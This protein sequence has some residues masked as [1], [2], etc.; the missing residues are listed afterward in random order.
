MGK[1]RVL[2]RG[3]QQERGERERKGERRKKGQDRP[4]VIGSMSTLDRSFLWR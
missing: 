1:E 4:Q 3:G 2:G